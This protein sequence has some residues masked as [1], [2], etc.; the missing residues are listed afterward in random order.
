MEIRQEIKEYLKWLVAAS[1]CVS[2]NDFWLSF[3]LSEQIFPSNKTILKMNKP[4]SPNGRR[5]DAVRFEN[6]R[7]FLALWI[8]TAPWGPSQVPQIDAAG[9]LPPGMAWVSSPGVG[10]IHFE[11]LPN[12]LPNSKWATVA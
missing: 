6:E 11:F 12:F 10:W 4:T 1:K 5:E 3:I 8:R 9:P 7:R 2:S